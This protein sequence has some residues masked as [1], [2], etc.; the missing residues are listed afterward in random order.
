MNPWMRD[1]R[2]A[3]A[4]V[5]TFEAERAERR[6]DPATARM[7]YRDAGE[8]LASVALSVQR[9]HPNTRSDLAI[10]AVASFA[11]AGDFG[12]AVEF[13]RRVLAEAEAL[14][15]QGRIELARLVSEYASLGDPARPRPAGSTRGAQVREEVR[16]KFSL[17]RAA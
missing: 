13:G 8:A 5:D 10:A 17:K 11:R 9:D 6:G 1:P 14:S 12:R 3:R 2:V 4:E 15:E 16:R 7:R